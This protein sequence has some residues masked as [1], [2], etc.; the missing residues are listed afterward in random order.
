[1]VFYRKFF[2]GKTVIRGHYNRQT[3]D[4]PEH[5]VLLWE[6]II[7]YFRSV[8]CAYTSVANR[9][10]LVIFA[11]QLTSTN[12]LTWRALAITTLKTQMFC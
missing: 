10:A 5:S 11:T 2:S 9:R 4:T 12:L 8:C 7:K 3:S 6:N 1:M